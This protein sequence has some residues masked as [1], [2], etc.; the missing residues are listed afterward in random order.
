MDSIC[1]VVCAMWRHNIML[2]TGQNI[3]N[4]IVWFQSKSGWPNQCELE[5]ILDVLLRRG[6]LS[7]HFSPV[8]H[9]EA[10]CPP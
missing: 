9:T 3:E 7:G 6:G 2:N 4:G 1:G 8:P 10:S 5:N